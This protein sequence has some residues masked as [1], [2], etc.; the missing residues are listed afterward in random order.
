M[1]VTIAVYLGLFYLQLDRSFYRALTRISL[2]VENFHKCLKIARHRFPFWASISAKH[3]LLIMNKGSID[4][5]FNPRFCTLNLWSLVFTTFGTLDLYPRKV[6]LSVQC[7]KLWGCQI[8]ANSSLYVGSGESENL[9]TFAEVG[10][11]HT[12]SKR[13]NFGN[14]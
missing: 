2:S 8:F 5:G 9:E 14:F 10:C 3:L 4:T 7:R 6:R 1:I 13:V 12:A 11:Y